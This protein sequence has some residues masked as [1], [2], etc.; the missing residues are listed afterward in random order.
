[1]PFLQVSAANAEDLLVYTC[2]GG[3][4]RHGCGLQGLRVFV[5]AAFVYR[6]WPDCAVTGFHC[7]CD[8]SVVGSWF[9]PLCSG[10]PR[11]GILGSGFLVE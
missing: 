2:L 9:R 4:S 8:R 5:Y 11:F 1:M 3:S 7:C 10:I 6:L